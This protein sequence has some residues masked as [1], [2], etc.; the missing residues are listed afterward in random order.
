MRIVAALLLTLAGAV[1][2][3]DTGARAEM[4][5]L[6]EVNSRVAELIMQA[7]QTGKPMAEVM[8]LVGDSRYNQTLV[9]AAYK[10]P[11][12]RTEEAQKSEITEFSNSV[13]G[14]CVSSIP[15][16]AK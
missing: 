10:A 11:L 16:D 15:T 4:M 3:A 6:C 13:F 14:A 2:A 12:F 8:K 1:Y 5:K 9:E 7:R